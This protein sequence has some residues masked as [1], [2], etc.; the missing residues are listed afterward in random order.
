[1]PG[2][3]WCGIGLDIPT[4]FLSL[5]KSLCGRSHLICGVLSSFLLLKILFLFLC[6]V[7]PSPS[8]PHLPYPTILLILFKL[9]TFRLLVLIEFLGLTCR[10]VVCFVLFGPSYEKLSVV[11]TS[12]SLPFI[13]T[14]KLKP[15][16]TCSIYPHVF[17]PKLPRGGVLVQLSK[18]LTN[19]THIVP[20]QVGWSWWPESL[21]VD[22]TWLNLRNILCSN[23][24]FFV[25]FP[26]NF[27]VLFVCSAHATFK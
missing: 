25:Q 11:G 21:S 18:P 9:S 1:M 19:I 23:A 24:P 3:K 16:H 7:V 8:I 5:Q 26:N 17:V 22:I 15:V 12:F 2:Q 6:S 4:A 10:Y 13:R 27:G 20:C 14:S